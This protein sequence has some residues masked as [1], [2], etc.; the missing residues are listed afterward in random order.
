MF[1]EYND[2]KPEDKIR[3]FENEKGDLIFECF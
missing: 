1:M 2:M 3:E